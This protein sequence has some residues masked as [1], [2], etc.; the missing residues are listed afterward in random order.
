MCV[1]VWIILPVFHPRWSLFTHNLIKSP[2]CVLWYRP[3]DVLL[4][5][6]FYTFPPCIHEHMD[7]F[8]QTD[9]PHI[10]HPLSVAAVDRISD[11]LCARVR[12]RQ[13]L[14]LKGLLLWNDACSNFKWGMTSGL[15][16]RAGRI[17]RWMWEPVPT[18]RR[19]YLKHASVGL[20]LL[21]ALTQSVLMRSRQT[22]R[23]KDV[24]TEVSWVNWC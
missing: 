22:K 17:D 20:V 23:H 19:Y 14:S 1:C 13:R 24:S 11:P 10:V 4:H 15:R 8:T 9:N 7:T 16:E 6:Y 21:K 3:P 2:R 12:K 5:L 18:H